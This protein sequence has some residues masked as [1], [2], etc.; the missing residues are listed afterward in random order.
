MSRHASVGYPW[1]KI[2]SR[3]LTH[4][5]GQQTVVPRDTRIKLP[6]GLVAPSDIPI[7]DT[8]AVVRYLFSSERW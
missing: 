5:W 3:V 4:D 2:L 6:N 1:F 7:S 8:V